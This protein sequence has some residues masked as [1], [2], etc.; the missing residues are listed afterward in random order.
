[1]F[2]EIKYKSDAKIL[3]FGDG[4]IQNGTEFIAKGRLR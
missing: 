2:L 1:M 4:E 3:E